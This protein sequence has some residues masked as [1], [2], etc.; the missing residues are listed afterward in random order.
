MTNN[1]LKQEAVYHCELNIDDVV[2]YNKFFEAGICEGQYKTLSCKVT[3]I[4][5]SKYDIWYTTSKGFSFRD[6]DIGK[7]YFTSEYDAKFAL[8]TR[9]GIEI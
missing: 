3:T 1:N 2:Y 8:E 9:T 7:M 6:Y 5:V 4:N